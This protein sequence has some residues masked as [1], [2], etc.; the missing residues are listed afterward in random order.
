MNEYEKIKTL[1]KGSF[2][3]AA[4]VRH[5]ESKRLCVA[6]RIQVAPAELER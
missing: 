2:G 6:K 4:L 3:E 5:K 1:G